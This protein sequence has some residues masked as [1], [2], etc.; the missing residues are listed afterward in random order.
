MSHIRNSATAL[1][2][3]AS[4]LTS[5]AAF[6]HSEKPTKI[7]VA[8]VLDTTG[9]MGGLLDGAKK[10][11]WSIAN[12]IIDINPNAD[13]R[14][15]LVGYRD[16]GDDYVTKVF[17]ISDDI[18]G[19]YGELQQY[20][21]AGGGDSPEAVNEALDASL[22]KLQWSSSSNDEKIIF[23]VGDAPPHMDYQGPKYGEIIKRARAKDIKINAIQAGNSR[24]TRRYWQEIAQLGNGTYINLP[25]DGGKVVIIDTPYDDQIIILQQKINKTIIPYGNQVQQ[26]SV[27][28][29]MRKLS[30]APASEA[31]GSAKYLAKKSV[32]RD[33]I[34]GAGDLVGD[35]RNGRLKI[36]SVKTENLPKEFRG[37][38]TKELEDLIST[39]IEKR[40][41]LE[42]ELNNLVN[43]HDEYVKEKQAEI[44]EVK[45]SSFDRSVEKLLKTQI[46]K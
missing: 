8:F 13:I 12:K 21:A 29:K 45:T 24:Q 15:G 37:K 27:R 33:A 35:V 16:F 31:V 20:Q 25:Q 36:E 6:A 28:S 41:Q 10:K 43:Q 1:A 3:L 44:G 26:K 19:L 22:T 23:L 11:I 2:L 30:S 40:K 32:G 9:S 4:L 39:R 42:K 14:M 38:S 18:Q 7:E 17:N 34:T 5:S 46:G